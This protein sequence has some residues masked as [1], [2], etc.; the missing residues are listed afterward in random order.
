MTKKVIFTLIALF[1]L[2]SCG[3]ETELP[4]PDMK[5]PDSPPNPVLMDPSSLPSTE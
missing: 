4:D 5:F 3:N 1:L 2:T